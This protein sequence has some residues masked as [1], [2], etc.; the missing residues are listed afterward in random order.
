MANDQLMSARIFSLDYPRF[1][2][3]YH[4]FPLDYPRFA[5]DYRSFPLDYRSFPLYYRSFSLDYPLEKTMYPLL[6]T[7]PFGALRRYY[8][9]SQCTRL[10]RSN[11]V[12]SL[13]SGKRL[14]HAL[15]G[16]EGSLLRV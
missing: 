14:K 5:L 2:L 12:R 9:N 15:S 11:D 6:S 7:S 16:T 1:P 13:A 10:T 3:D 8:G 4:R